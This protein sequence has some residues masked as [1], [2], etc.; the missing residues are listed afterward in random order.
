MPVVDGVDGDRFGELVRID[1]IMGGG[2]LSSIVLLLRQL[3]RYMRFSGEVLSSEQFSQILQDMVY[4]YRVRLD[5]KDLR[6]L[7]RLREDLFVTL[8]EVAD[9]T[10]LSFTTVQRRRKILEDRCRFGVYARLD[11][12]RMGVLLYVEIHRIT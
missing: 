3:S 4:D 11:Y 5:G 12:S 7:N 6:I 9:D 1:G 2:F 10:G 8:N